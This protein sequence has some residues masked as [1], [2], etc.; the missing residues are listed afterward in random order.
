MGH[1]ERDWQ[2]D[3][4]V[5]EFTE[6]RPDGLGLRGLGFRG[7]GFMGLGFGGLGYDAYAN[8]YCYSC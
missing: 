8:Y 5:Q 7:V 1:D 3:V 2:Q 4:Q 6:W